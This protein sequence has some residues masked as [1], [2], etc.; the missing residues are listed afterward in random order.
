M[1]R[2]RRAKREITDEGELRELLEACQVV[3]VGAMDAD[4]MFI[5]PMNFGF[6]WLGRG[7]G[8]DG[9]PVARIYLH[10]AQE[11]RKAA[12]WGANGRGGVPVAIELDRDDG[13]ITGEYACAYSRAY[14]SIMGSGSIVP[15]E[16]SEERTHA[17]ELLMEHAA[18]GAPHAFAPEAVERVAVFRIDVYELTGKKREPKA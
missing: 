10:S 4:G 13:T 8:A 9:S 12:C 6:E 14:V 7:E 17:L 11:G 16:D 3:R 5:V 1:R 15:A 18:P 2:M